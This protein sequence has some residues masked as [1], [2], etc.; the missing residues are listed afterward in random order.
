M[1]KL[2]DLADERGVAQRLASAVRSWSDDV[3][4]YKG[5]RRYGDVLLRYLD[6]RAGEEEGFGEVDPVYPF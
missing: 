5:K 6:E 4:E 1:S 3:A 2:E